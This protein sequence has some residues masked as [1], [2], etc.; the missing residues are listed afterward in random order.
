MPFVATLG[1][2]PQQIL[3]FSGDSRLVVTKEFPLV[4]I[5]VATKAHFSFKKKIGRIFTLISLHYIIDIATKYTEGNNIRT[6]YYQPNRLY[7]KVYN[8]LL[9]IS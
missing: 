6:F 9:A 2:S 1:R 4:A 5:C 3:T 7:N 8:I